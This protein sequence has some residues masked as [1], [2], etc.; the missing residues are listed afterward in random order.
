VG[1]TVFI[2]ED[3]LIDTT[4]DGG[5]IDVA[6]LMCYIDFG[7]EHLAASSFFLGVLALLGPLLCELSFYFWVFS[8]MWQHLHILNLVQSLLM[9]NSNL[10]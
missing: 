7:F 5:T 4:G 8:L 6:F 9:M 1:K 10:V 2:L 3:Y